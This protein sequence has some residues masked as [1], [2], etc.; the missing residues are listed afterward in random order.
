MDL[1]DRMGSM[2]VVPMTQD[3][4]WRFSDPWKT[5]L[6]PGLRSEPTERDSRV[7]P[8]RHQCKLVL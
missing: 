3:P 7:T 6:L 2:K 8:K 5:T 4:V 1:L